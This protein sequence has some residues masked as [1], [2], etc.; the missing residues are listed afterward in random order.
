M[1]KNKIVGSNIS[2]KIDIS[3]KNKLFNYGISSSEGLGSTIYELFGTDNYGY[4]G[5][6]NLESEKV[7]LMIYI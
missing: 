6:R 2:K 3:H 1:R 7:N 5:N 4:S